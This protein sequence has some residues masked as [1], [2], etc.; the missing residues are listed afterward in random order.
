M[1]RILSGIIHVHSLYS[2]DGNHSLYEIREAAVR[3]RLDFV[4]I[5]EHSDTL[6]KEK[7]RR[8]VAECE[9]LSSSSFVMIPGIEFTCDDDLHLMGIGIREYTDSSD[10]LLVNEFIQRLGGLA[11]VA[12][13]L[14]KNYK[15][16]DKLLSIVDGLE[17]WNCG[18]DGRFFP[19]AAAV[20]VYARAREGN[21][22]LVAFSGVDLHRLSNLHQTYTRL[23]SENLS[24]QA[25]LQALRAGKFS[26]VS[27]WCRI[28]ALPSWNPLQRHRFHLYQQLYRSAKRLK[29]VLS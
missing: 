11:V 2:Y 18:Y 28:A 25:V 10:S 22:R 12:H 24:E 5:T 4:C 26:G 27:P 20:D 19:N 3:R 1:S 9:Q 29:R 13:P 7:V 23:E 17:I 8:L 6:D 15:M 21:P 16:P 14:R